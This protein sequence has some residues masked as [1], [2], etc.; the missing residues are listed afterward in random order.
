MHKTQILLGH[1][2]QIFLQGKQASSPIYQ[3]SH[4]SSHNS[5]IISLL[6]K[7]PK[8]HPVQPEESY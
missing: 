7:N 5:Q 1:R 8:P 4:Y 3:D 6:I 2:A